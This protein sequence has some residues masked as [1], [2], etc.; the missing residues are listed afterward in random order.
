LRA[1]AEE[2]ERLDLAV[3]VITFEARA[4]AEM[5][6]REIGLAWPLLVD[7]SRAV[8]RAYGMPRGG[9]W[10]IWSPAS[11]G[12]YLDLMRKGRRLRL[13]TGDMYQL[14]GDVLIDPA[15]RIA[16]H[17]VERGPADRPAVSEVLTAVRQARGIG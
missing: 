9:L 10:E 8:Y 15:G 1:Q 3:L 13:P 7:T 11:W 16:W 14:G 17:R 2:I 4:L 6:V 5:Y 12:T